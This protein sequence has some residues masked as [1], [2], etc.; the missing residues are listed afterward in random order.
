LTSLLVACGGSGSVEEAAKSLSGSTDNSTTLSGSAIKGAIENGIVQAYLIDSNDGEMSRNSQVLAGPVRTDRHGNYQLSIDGEYSD[1]SVLVELTADANTRMTCDVTDGCG[2]NDSGAVISYGEQFSLNSDF[3]LSGMITGVDTGDTLDVHLSPL[4]HMAVAYAQSSTGGMTKSNITDAIS[5]IEDLLELDSGAMSLAPADITNLEKYVSL[6]KSEIEMGVVSAAFLSLVNSDDWESIA[7]VLEYVTE[8]IE[9]SGRL[10]SVNQDADPEVALDDLFSHASDIIEDIVTSDPTSTFS[11]QLN[12]V[13]VETAASLQDIENDVEGVSAV[14]IVSQPSGQI[15]DEGEQV[16]LSVSATG[17]GTIAYQWRKDGS[18]IAGETDSTLSFS[19]AEL[20][21]DGVYDVIVSNSVG[22]VTS[23][24]ALLSV[25]QV[26]VTAPVEIASQPVSLDVDEGDN[27]TFSVSAIGGGTISFQWR[28]DGV[29]IAGE[30][31]N[32]LTLS[33]ATVADSGSYDVVVTNSIGEVISSSAS[34]GVTETA[35]TLT[36]NISWDIPEERED[37]SDL[38]LSD[39]D[40][41]IIVYGTDASNLDSSIIVEG[42]SV[43]STQIAELESGTYFF[44][45]ATVDSDGMVSQYT[46]NVQG[47]I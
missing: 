28:K 6:T 4:T 17:G 43:N 12:Q 3:V 45:I 2:T 9:A 1:R 40:G 18:F 8:K 15:V 42:A 46:A 25:N 26:I 14:E 19:S 44:S 27:A 37:G 10:S 32:S 33:E 24:V 47:A 36:Y 22:D 21:D 34:L 13:S 30:T 20:E 16:T 11:Q 35:A 5:H 39:I 31:D 23:L 38:D 41:Y 29:A 7:D